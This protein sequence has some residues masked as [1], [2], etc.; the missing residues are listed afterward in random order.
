MAATDTCIAIAG[1]GSIG[2]YVGACLLL[3]GRRVHM[4]ARGATATALQ[5]GGLH[6]TSLDGLDRTLAPSEVAVSSDPAEALADAGVILLTVKS[7]GTAAMAETVARHARPGAIVVSLQNGVANVA[8]LRE[9]LGTLHPVVPGMVPFNVIQSIAPHGGLRVHRATSGTILIGPAPDAALPALLDVPHARVAVHGDMPA[10]QWGKLLLN[11]NNALNALS[12]IPLAAQLSDAAW[13]RLLAEQ[14]QE[15]L[16]CFKA[17]GIRAIG[18]DGIPLWLAPKILRLPDP[19][20]QLVARRMLA[21][22]PEA[23]SSM[24][25]DLE[26]RR[27]TEIDHLQGAVLDLARR[28]GCSLP[29]TERIV[30]AVK[31]AEQAGAGSPGLRPGDIR[32]A[33]EP[34]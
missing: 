14:M 33:R 20:F 30:A 22:D 18:A 15:A 32:T 11:L 16:G 29:V 2:C 13:R 17:S 31:A 10:I 8:V 34:A 1:A 7:G 28:T 19:L 23:R 6:V 9:R 4:L 12:G 26:K 3:A 24:W 25:E 21:V 5:R 27:S